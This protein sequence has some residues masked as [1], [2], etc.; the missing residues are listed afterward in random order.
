MAL[1]F[2]FIHTILQSAAARSEL[3]I[4]VVNFNTH[5]HSTRVYSVMYCK[6]AGW[7]I[8]RVVYVVAYRDYVASHVICNFYVYFTFDPVAIFLWHPTSSIGLSPP[9]SSSQRFIMLHIP[10]RLPTGRQPNRIAVRVQLVQLNYKIHIELH[11]NL[12]NVYYRFLCR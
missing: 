10:A 2:V 8:F 7:L 11:R 4:K 9:L 3:I 6:I 5:T 1:Q 12:L